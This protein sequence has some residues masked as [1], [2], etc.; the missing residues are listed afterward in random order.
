MLVKGVTGKARR[1]DSISHCLDLGSFLLTFLTVITAW[2]SNRMSSKVWE[3]ITYPFPQFNSSTTVEVWK[4]ISMFYHGCNY[5]SMLELKLNH[6]PG[7]PRII[8][9]LQWFSQNNPG[10]TQ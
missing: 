10:S 6:A 7:F 9:A 4:C 3:E 2:I 5:L 8:Q 1:R